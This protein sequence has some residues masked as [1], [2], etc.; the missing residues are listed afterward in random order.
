MAK[1]K[2]TDFFLYRRRFLLTGVF[3]F[4]ALAALLYGALTIPGGLTTAEQDSSVKAVTSGIIGIDS[5]Y[6][7]LQHLSIKLLGLTTIS[8]KL[9]SILLAAVFAVIMFLLFRRWLAPATA[10]F[11]A[12]LLFSGTTFLSLAGTGSPAIL[13]VLYPAILLFFG[14]RIAAHDKVSV[15]FAL[16]LLVTL[17]AALL[18]PTTIYLVVLAVVIGLFNPH[19]RYGFRR[20]RSGGIILLALGFILAFAPVAY[21]VFKD[22][23]ILETLLAVPDMV[24][25]AQIGTNI[26]ELYFMFGRFLHP[27]IVNG[28]IAPVVGLSA[29]GLMILGLYRTIRGIYSARSQFLIGWSIIAL[30]I[31]VFNPAYA[32]IAYLPIVLLAIFGLGQLIAI[33]YRT[34]PLNPYAR[35]SAMIPIGIL[36]AGVVIGSTVR[37]V[38]TVRYASGSAELYSHDL[39]LL[40]GYLA[41]S[42]LTD[43][44]LIVPDADVAFYANLHNAAVT[45][46]IGTNEVQTAQGTTIAAWQYDTLRQPAR[47][48]TDARSRSA[49]RFYVYR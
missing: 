42:K 20:L 7:L 18:T 25:L 33:W 32:I 15:L 6:Y 11:G 49:D 13:Y 2:L 3:V 41:S 24:S 46:V 29:V 44:T 21:A 1:T 36:I 19:V 40:E 12:L 43:V 23:S 34:F 30:L 31:V 27:G 10:V 16:L 45:R 9:P 35:F 4:L 14:T 37:Y 38:N 22:P 39:Q 26:H 5:P 47:V 48:L 28:M 17:A 8:I